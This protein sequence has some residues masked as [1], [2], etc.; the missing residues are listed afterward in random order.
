MEGGV[1]KSFS[2]SLGLIVMIVAVS[3]C[4]T[5]SDYN[6][7][8]GIESFEAVVID[9]FEGPGTAGFEFSERVARSIQ[10]SG[11]FSQI[12]REE[13]QGEALRIRGKIT[14]YS[15]GNPAMR[16]RYGHNI[17]NARFSAVVQIEDFATGDF[18]ASFSLSETYDTTR[19]R[20]RLHQ[21][22]DT[23]V[24]RAAIRLGEKLADLANGRN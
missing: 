18:V 16:L 7:F 15:R 12:L 13:P 17:G 4:R 23:L 6:P 10:S 22:L 20:E 21:D 5:V 11:L 3:G 8:A 9:D 19:D 14:R 2:V 24:E 1:S